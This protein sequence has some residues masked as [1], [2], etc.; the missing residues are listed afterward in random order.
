MN[1]TKLFYLE[2]RMNIHEVVQKYD[3][4]EAAFKGYVGLDYRSNRMLL[5]GKSVSGVNP[6]LAADRAVSIATRGRGRGCRRTVID[7]PTESICIHGDNLNSI[8]ILETIYGFDAA[9]SDSTPYDVLHSVHAG[10]V[11][12]R[13]RLTETN[14]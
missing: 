14:S 3:D 12:W 7:L 8:E 1:D 13:S 9:R 2:M 5:V 11:D 4:L 6:E 10:G